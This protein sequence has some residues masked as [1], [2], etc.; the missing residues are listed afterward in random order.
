MPTPA[1]YKYYFEQL[2]PVTAGHKQLVGAARA[3]R[4]DREVTV[5]IAGEMRLESH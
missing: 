5:E 4:K 3:A 2:G 1:E